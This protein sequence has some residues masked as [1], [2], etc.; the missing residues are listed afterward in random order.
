MSLDPSAAIIPRSVA[1]A[2]VIKDEQIFFSR[3]MTEVFL[4]A[5]RMAS[6]CTTMIAGT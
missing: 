5:I 1:R 3:S 4:P 6:A 2:I